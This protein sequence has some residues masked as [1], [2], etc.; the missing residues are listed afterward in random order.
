MSNDAAM[1]KATTIRTSVKAPL[2]QP[3][4][5]ALA[6]SVSL[7]SPACL[8]ADLA[9]IAA[10]RR[11]SHGFGTISR[12]DSPKSSGTLRGLGAGSAAQGLGP[13]ST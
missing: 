6:G 5:E 3:P 12:E 9:R 10:A 7:A 4:P 8:E 1:N 2:R 11:L 13:G